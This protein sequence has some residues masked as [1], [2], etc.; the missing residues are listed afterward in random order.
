TGCTSTGGRSLEA[1]FFFQAEDGIRAFHVTGV[2]TC[3]LPIYPTSSRKT[4][5]ASRRPAWR[6]YAGRR[7]IGAL[8]AMPGFGI[9]IPTARTRLSA[10]RRLCPLADF[11]G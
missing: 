5:V 9:S 11:I 7:N 8:Y 2:Q 4:L 10:R 3:A 6:R 1:V